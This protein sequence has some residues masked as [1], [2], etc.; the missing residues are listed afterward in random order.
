MGPVVSPRLLIAEVLLSRL[1]GFKP[2]AK[3]SLVRT[4]HDKPAAQQL[5][6]NDS[7]FHGFLSWCWQ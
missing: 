5:V 7:D 4:T 1:L 2:P 3:R 6:K